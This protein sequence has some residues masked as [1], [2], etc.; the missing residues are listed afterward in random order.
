M[1]RLSPAWGS[2]TT[3]YLGIGAPSYPFQIPV[4]GGPHIQTTSRN[5][6]KTFWQI[7]V[8][9]CYRIPPDCAS[10]L[11]A[12]ANIGLFALWAAREAP[13]AR[14][15]SVEPSPETFELLQQNIRANSLEDRIFPMRCALA[16][17]NGERQ[18]AA[19]GASPT[20]RLLLR[21]S[22]H[23]GQPT[24]AVKCTT[25]ADFLQAHQIESLDLLKMDVEGSEWEILFSTPPSVLRRI[26]HI[27]LEYHE[28]HASFGYHPN[29]LFAHLAVAGHKLTH[30]EEDESRTGLAFLSL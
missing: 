6:V 28:V 2:I 25:L 7:F 23:D 15:I 13:R 12:G 11:D 24:V 3:R 4:Y 14:I 1:W 18:M 30:H 16:G 10:I 20:R 29:Q 22:R 27:M 8:R 17:Q 5:E 19:F 9:Q 26:R 21:P